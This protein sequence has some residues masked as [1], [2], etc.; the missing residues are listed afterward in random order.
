MAE[1][2][3]SDFSFEDA[4]LNLGDFLKE[5]NK[6][7]SRFVTDTEWTQNTIFSVEIDTF[8]IGIKVAYIVKNIS[9]DDVLEFKYFYDD[10]E[11]LLRGT[12]EEINVNFGTITV[13]IYSIKRI[14]NRRTHPRFDVTICCYAI[15]D[16]RQ[17]HTYAITN[18]I[19]KGGISLQ[20]KADMDI[21]QILGLNLYLSKD[22]II[23]MAVKI[24][25]KKASNSNFIYDTKIESINRKSESYFNELISI[26]EQYDDEL[27]FKYINSLNKSE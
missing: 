26:L 3:L 17:K 7:K 27:Y 14:K 25:R 5:G 24:L 15:P 11:Y 2:F 13:R 16:I 21:G 12:V 8:D 1:N 22:R 18:N 19:S 10:F 20:T 4:T 9:D 23:S 6:I